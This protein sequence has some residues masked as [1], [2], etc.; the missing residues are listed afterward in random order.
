MGH[1][2]I[3]SVSLD[4]GGDSGVCSSQYVVYLFTALLFMRNESFF[5]VYD[6]FESSFGGS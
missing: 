6:F 1:F 5:Q 2:I 4:I 3:L